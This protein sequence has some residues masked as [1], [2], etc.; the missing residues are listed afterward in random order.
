MVPR[1]FPYIVVTPLVIAAGCATTSTP[2]RPPE[3]V[4]MDPMRILPKPDPLVGLDS[5]DAGDLLAKGNELFNDGDFD[6]ALKLFS[7]LV[8]QFAESSLMAAALYNKGLCLERL[9]EYGA[10]AEQYQRVIERHPSSTSAKDAYYRVSLCL[11]KLGRWREVETVFWALRQRENLP[12]MD[13]LE[14]RVGL[15]IAL[16][17]QKEYPTAEREFLSALR[18]YNEHSKKQFLP[19]EYWVGQ[20]R[21]YLGEIFARQFEAHLI[22]SKQSDEAA[23]KEDVAKKLEEKCELLLRAQNNFIR[24]IRVGHTGWA[25]A[26]GYRIG[27]LY[28]RL[29]DDM[30]AVGVPIGLE[31]IAQDVYFEELRKRVAVLVRKAIRVYERS[32]DMAQR[33]GEDNEWVER[34]SKA[35]ERMKELALGSLES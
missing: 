3:V 20:S 10:A 24:A 14:A 4:Q 21:F 5:Y 15:A 7:R 33:V 32:L 22:D 6:V 31:Q 29:Y 18:F 34:T 27:S 9:A 19:A 13:E 11:S 12:V 28:E 26:S 8:E 25:T 30:L 16:F 35:L 1:A 23:W 2:A 17:M